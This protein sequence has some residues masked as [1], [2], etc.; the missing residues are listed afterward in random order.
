MKGL[1]VSRFAGLAICGSSLG[2]RAAARSH[3]RWLGR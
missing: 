2:C 1:H 3:R